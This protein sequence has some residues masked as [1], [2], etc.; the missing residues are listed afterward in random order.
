MPKE[1][2]VVT[3]VRKMIQ[4]RLWQLFDVTK[5]SLDIDQHVTKSH[6][7]ILTGKKKDL[8]CIH[9]LEKIQTPL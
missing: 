3:E 1:K 7:R 9:F 4:P 8:T 2:V 5:R 6:W